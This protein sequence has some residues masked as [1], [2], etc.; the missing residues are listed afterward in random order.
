MYYLNSRYYNPEWGRFIN[1]DGLVS[2]GQGLLSHNMYVYCYNNLINMCDINGNSAILNGALIGLTT[3]IGSIITASVKVQN[4]IVTINTNEPPPPET[5]YK[6]P[7]SK[8]PVKKQPAPGSKTG[9]KGWPDKKGDIWVPDLDMHG[10]AGW[11]VH[12][13][14]GEHRHV[15]PNGKIRAHQYSSEICW[16]AGGYNLYEV[17]I[18]GKKCLTDVPPSIGNSSLNDNLYFFPILGNTPMLPS[19]SMGLIP[20]FGI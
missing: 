10:G 13:P 16:D 18:N 3:T 2:T 17:T 20:A 11:R 19:F 5:G 7:K 9:E 1:A 4:N 15:Y 8:S 12:S 6:A 14:N